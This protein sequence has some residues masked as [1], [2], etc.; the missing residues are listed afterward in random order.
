MVL[1]SQWWQRL[2]RYSQSW[3]QDGVYQASLV[4]GGYLITRTDNAILV[5][6]IDV[7]EAWN[8]QVDPTN[9]VLTTRISLSD[10]M[11]LKFRLPINP[12]AKTDDLHYIGKWLGKLF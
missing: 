11:N 7:T 3:R 1:S 4:W 9:D 12:F 6:G 8:K 2:V 5:N 10:F